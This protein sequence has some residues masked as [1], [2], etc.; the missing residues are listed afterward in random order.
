MVFA[1]ALSVEDIVL[2]SLT[3]TVLTVE[4]SNVT[5]VTSGDIVKVF[6]PVPSPA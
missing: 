5:P 3:F 2:A 4:V 6:V 1:V